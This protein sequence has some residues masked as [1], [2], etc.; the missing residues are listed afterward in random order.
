MP[1]AFNR[2]LARSSGGR[3]LLDADRFAFAWVGAFPV[4]PE[5]P[6]SRPAEIGE[7]DGRDNRDAHECGEQKDGHNIAAPKSTPS[8]NEHVNE[9]H[10]YP[11]KRNGECLTSTRA[12]GDGRRPPA[13]RR[14]MLA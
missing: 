12:T 9:A 14:L 13:Y 5:S 1:C 11:S 6:V 10:R 3:G 8:C 2:L 4:G 7:L